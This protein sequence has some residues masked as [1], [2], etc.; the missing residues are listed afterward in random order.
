[1]LDISHLQP[2]SQRHL[3]WGAVLD[4]DLRNLYM[5]P[6]LQEA[7]LYAHLSVCSS[8]LETQEWKVEVQL[9]STV[10]SWHVEVMILC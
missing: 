1:M 7:T 3:Q 9:C 4:V 8:R 6:S 5:R 10:S 2:S